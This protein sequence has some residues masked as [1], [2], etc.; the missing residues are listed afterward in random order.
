MVTSKPFL[1]AAALLLAP[2]AAQAAELTPAQQAFRQI[3]QELVEINTTDSIG[4]TAKA[5]EA[6]AVRL[7][8]AGLA[9]VQVLS[10][11]PRKGNLVAR[12][13]GTGARKPI[14]L[15]AHLDVV[16]ALASD[17]SFDPFK[18]TEKDGYFY[19][20]GTGDDKFMAAT[21]VANLIRYKQENFTPNRD[22]IL[23]L[24]TDEE[25][26]DSDGLGVQWLV[27]NHRDLIDAEYALNEGGGVGIKNG[28]LI[29]NSLQTMEKVYL[30]YRLE[31]LNKGGHSSVPS[32]DNAIYHLAEGLARLGKF[33][34]PVN[35][36]AT[37][38]GYFARAAELESPQTAADIRSVLSASPDPAAL[39]RLSANPAYNAQ[40]RTTCVATMLAGGHAVNALPQ[41]AR[42][43]INCRIMPGEKTASR[44]R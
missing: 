38:R 26:G 3:Y 37:T 31:V 7:R 35:L 9:D 40:L 44:R 28:K 24:E 23:A 5:A 25:I 39:A 10:S 13:R 32:T 27:K 1:V 34:F 14:L 15:M 18:L 2:A 33:S 19:G 8:T 41:T 4:D 17:W 22:I 29:R 36:N 42:A 16:E 11:G 43:L 21:F 20:R 12:L 6:M 30:N